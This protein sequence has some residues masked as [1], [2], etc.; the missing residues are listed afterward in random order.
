M[1]F[2]INVAAL[3]SR[4]IATMKTGQRESLGRLERS[5]GE[6]EGC[7]W[8]HAASLG[9]FEQGRPLIERLRRE[10]PDQKILLTFFSPSGYEVRKN[11]ERVDSVAYLPL[12]TPRRVRRFLDAVKPSMAVFVK[13]EFWGN[14]L[15]ELRRRSIPT[16]LISAIFRPSQAFFKPWGSTFRKM[17]GCYDKIFLQDEA[18]RELLASIGVEN[19]E[20][21]GDTRFD[22]V[23]DI[24]A[25]TFAMD[26]VETF[27]K[28][29]K[30]RMIVGSSWEPDEDLYVPYLDA[31]PEVKA[32]V[33]P[34][35]MCG[36]RVDRLIARFKNG[37]VRLSDIEKGAVAPDCEAQ[38]VVADCFGKL[39]SLYRYGQIA[40]VGG[41]FGE[42]IH[43]INEAA[44]Y[45]M[46]VIFGPKYAKFKEARD[47]VQLRGAFSISNASGLNSLL[48]RFLTDGEALAEASTTAG[49]YIRRNIGATDRIFP[50]LF[51]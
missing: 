24:M 37:A 50:Q 1:G 36:D 3:R 41:G 32:V 22:R 31:H 44:V 10:R 7:V 33:A 39:A 11:Y 14:Y 8:I 25:S 42:G 4:K 51:K 49:D 26:E 38:V 13:Y 23:T 40:Y 17:L 45:D 6:L 16:Y 20:V 19:T 35:E 43:N 9:E 5:A 48:N 46:P 27:L 28:P 15:R 18:S 30:L 2:G 29:A 12:D 34:H 21:A 47:L